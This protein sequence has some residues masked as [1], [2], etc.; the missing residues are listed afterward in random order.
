MISIP[1]YFFPLTSSLPFITHFSILHL[2]NIQ[3][4]TSPFSPFPT[5]KHSKYGILTSSWL[6]LT[7][8]VGNYIP[9][10][11]CLGIN[12]SSPCHRKCPSTTR[13]LV[14]LL[15]YRYHWVASTRRHHQSHPAPDSPVGTL[16]RKLERT[17]V[18]FPIGLFQVLC[19]FSGVVSRKACLCVCV[20]CFSL[21]MCVRVLRPT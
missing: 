4:P 3:V 13:S 12:I 16:A 9:Y 2:I 17:N 6:I 7:V 11:E 5:P 15:P 14:P 8:N 20:V 1:N 21:N 10:I 19:W 18:P